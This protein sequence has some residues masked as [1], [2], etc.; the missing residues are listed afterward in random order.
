[1]NGKLV[2]SLI[3][4]F[5]FQHQE[6][7]IKCVFVIGFDKLIK[8]GYVTNG[9]PNI[10]EIIDYASKLQQYGRLLQ[11]QEPCDI[12]H[13]LDQLK[14]EISKLT[15]QIQYNNSI[16]QRQTQRSHERLMQ[17]ASPIYDDR[18]RSAS[19][20]FKQQQQQL[21]HKKSKEITP[22][23]TQI[24]PQTINQIHITISKHHLDDTEIKSVMRDNLIKD[25]P[26]KPIKT[27]QD[28]NNHFKKSHYV[29][30]QHPD[31][32]ELPVFEDTDRY[33][34]RD[35]YIPQYIQY[36]QHQHSQQQQ[37]QQQ[38]QLQQSQISSQSNTKQSDQNT[39]NTHNT[40]NTNQTFAQPQSSQKQLLQT[41]KSSHGQQKSPNRSPKFKYSQKQ[42]SK[43]NL[44]PVLEEN[45][46]LHAN[47][48]SSHSASSKGR[49]SNRQTKTQQNTQAV[50]KIKA[51]LDQDKKLHKQHLLEIASERNSFTNS[52]DKLKK[53]HDEHLSDSNH[54][55][56]NKIITQEMNES[57]HKRAFSNNS[58]YK[59]QQ[60]PMSP[61]LDEPKIMGQAYYNQF[62]GSI[63]RPN[64]NRGNNILGNPQAQD[65]ILIFSKY[66]QQ[67]LDQYSPKINYQY[68][69]SSVG[70]QQESELKRSEDFNRSSVSSTFSMF[71]PNEE[72][73]TF[74]QNDFLERK[75][76]TQQGYSDM[77]KQSSLN[78]SQ[79]NNQHHS[80]Y[81]S[82]SQ[83]EDQQNYSKHLYSPQ[84]YQNVDKSNVFNNNRLSVTRILNN[85]QI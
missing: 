78:S 33:P 73:K 39:Q 32:E 52:S 63:S 27:I 60:Q 77:M 14:D 70:K 11:V 49:A 80:K 43:K 16:M 6:M 84:Q 56:M 58:L 2:Q 66:K 76:Y 61:Q 72:L 8:K 82:T 74:F 29:D 26:P 40:H 21:V 79:E 64:S 5:P 54:S 20:G 17:N 3:N 59:Q 51:L 45:S 31:T 44:E 48:Q 9:K 25:K 38:Q 42:Q 35:N 46:Y 69:P 37:Q 67:V 75:R 28:N 10:H 12:R 85:S 47:Q 36:S 22:K 7:M 23:I 19:L 18:K 4:L 34:V 55:K 57:L 13:E 15:Q 41:S 53:M 1:M 30:Y 71:N 24:E 68:R 50:S 65:N 83:I 62:Q 81:I